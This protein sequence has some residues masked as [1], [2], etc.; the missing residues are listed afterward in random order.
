MWKK[1]VVGVFIVLL[2]LITIPTAPSSEAIGQRKW[3]SSDEGV[4]FY[5]DAGKCIGQTK[6][7]EGKIVKMHR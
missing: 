4:I 6:T 3:K 5:L 7:V 1:C 2:L